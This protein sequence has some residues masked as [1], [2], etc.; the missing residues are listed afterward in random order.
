MGTHCLRYHKEID[1]P[2][3]CLTHIVQRHDNGEYATC[4]DFEKEVDL[5]V[6]NAMQF[7]KV[8]SPDF[9]LCAIMQKDWADAKVR[10]S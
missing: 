8:D 6:N 3:T 5:M 2:K 9:I 4:R 7:A 10:A 1:G